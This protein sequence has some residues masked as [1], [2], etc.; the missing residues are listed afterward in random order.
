MK[1]ARWT[2]TDMSKAIKMIGEGA[3]Q[4]E[5][6]DAT[7]VSLSLLSQK[8][9]ELEC[10]HPDCTEDHPC[11]GAKRRKGGVMACMV[12]ENTVFE[13]VCPFFMTAEEFEENNRGRRYAKGTKHR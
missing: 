8:L 6:C 13:D 10:H 4:K 1:T 5:A 7:G 11:R 9:D 2:E 12:L 3:T